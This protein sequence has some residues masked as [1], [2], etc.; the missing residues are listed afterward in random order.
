MMGTIA[1]DYTGVNNY[2]M[3]AYHRL[4]LSLNYKLKSKVFDESIINFSI[5][6]IYGRSN[7][8][9][10]YYEIDKANNDDY[11]LS[12]NAKQVSLFP[13]MPSLSWRFKF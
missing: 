6:N 5:I 2:R 11:E 9:F 7:P 12:I 13:I 3:P 10:V 1:N 4:D 8:Y